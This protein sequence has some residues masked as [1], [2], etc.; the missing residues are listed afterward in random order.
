MGAAVTVAADD[1]SDQHARQR[2]ADGFGV[3]G[4][5]RCSVDADA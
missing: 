2:L 1:E 3:M 5:E 4:V